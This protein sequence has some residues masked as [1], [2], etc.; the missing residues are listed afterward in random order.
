MTL[1]TL[2]RR[3]DFL[4]VRGGAR[5]SLTS[6]TLEAKARPAVAGQADVGP[7]FGFT[8]TKRLGGAVV[9]NRI[10]RRLREAV[11]LCAQ[12]LARPG[13]DYVLIAKDGALK[14][15]FLDLLQDVRTALERVHTRQ[16]GDKSH[17]QVRREDGISQGDGQPRR[18]Q[19][20]DKA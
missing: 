15:P 12:E 6:F 19:R 8:V 7:R 10:R 13:Y 2:K 5:C 18:D 17:R 20:R 14:R 9:R 1:I 11:R 4:R 16:G 3:A